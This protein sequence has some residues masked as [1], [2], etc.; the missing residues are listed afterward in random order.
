LLNY[1][2]VITSLFGALIFTLVVGLKRPAIAPALMLALLLRFIA[3]FV[4][5]FII[6]L[7]ES[8]A[9]AISFE[10]HAW[11]LAEN[12]F[13]AALLSFE[14]PN[15]YFFSW[16][17]S[18]IYAVFGRNAMLA[19]SIS[20]WIS[21]GG[22]IVASSLAGILWGRWC[23]ARVA[24]MLAILPISVLYSVLILREVYIVFFLIVAC[25]Y[26]VA[27]VK[28]RRLLNILL[29]AFFFV[30]TGFFHGAMF[31]GVVV[32]FS[33]IFFT[34]LFRS[35]PDRWPDI[36]K[37]LI[38]SGFTALVVVGVFLLLALWEVYIPKF[39][40]IGSIDI[41]RVVSKIAKRSLDDASNGAAYPSW[42]LPESFVD[43]IWLFLP[44][45]AYLL[46]APFP[47]D[48]TKVIHILGFFDGLIYLFIIYSIFEYRRLILK[49]PGAVALL[50][51]AVCY[52]SIFSYGV[53][54]FGSGLRHRSTFLPLL[55]V[56][57]APLWPKF[58]RRLKKTPD[59]SSRQGERG[60]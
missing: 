25:Y 48:V 15:S 58:Y 24:L 50:I 36:T 34:E 56:L 44:R 29:T 52:L 35:L 4:N 60:Q 54:N 33:Y 17:L 12:G 23:E 42:L 14:G 46:F 19:E 39:G 20:I 26:F 41:E 6:P 38:V 22:I 1:L 5:N 28:T 18:L 11:L 8:T 47:W 10:A 45:L 40:N 13:Q 55:I 16:L 49:N 53:G 27:W 37:W 7:P 9:D 57:I 43:L 3:M 51:I 59:K 30:V 21:L 2:T 31:L 32:F